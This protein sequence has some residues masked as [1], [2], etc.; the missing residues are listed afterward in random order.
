MDNHSPMNKADTIK[1]L[2]EKNIAHDPKAPA[3]DL[4]ALLK[5]H[6]TAPA[7]PA[8]PAPQATGAI[9]TPA[10][11]LPSMPTPP[12]PSED[13]LAEVEVGEAPML[14]KRE[15]PLIVK[16]TDPNGWKNDEQARYAAILNGYAY[17]NP[18]KWAKKKGMLIAR[19][20]EIGNDPDALQK[21]MAA[22]GGVSF[23]DKRFEQ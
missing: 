7:A 13:D 18:K 20:I 4:T 11:P 5:A 17:R 1:A 19:L 16:P 9:V 3:K 14:E 15:L 23:K 10:V 6:T 21:Y 8:A 2:T 12:K 22:N